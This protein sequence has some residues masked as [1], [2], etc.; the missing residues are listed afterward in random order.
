MVVGIANH[1]KP[2]SC[3]PNR[4]ASGFVAA[5]ENLENS[6]SGEPAGTEHT[7]DLVEGNLLVQ[8]TPAIW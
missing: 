8:N 5:R 4:E 3:D 2:G 7:C 1:V 6:A